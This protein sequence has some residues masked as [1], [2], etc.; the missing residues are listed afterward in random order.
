MAYTAINKSTDYFSTKLYTGTGADNNA[1]TGI[2]HQPDWV[3]IKSRSGTHSAGVHEWYDSVRGTGKMISSNQTNAEATGTNRLKSFDSDGFTLGDHNQINGG[4]TNY[5]SWSWKAGTTSGITTTG[6]DITPSYYSMSATS[7]ISIIKFTGNGVDGAKIAHGLGAVPEM[8]ISKRLENSNYW[9]VFHKLDNTDYFVLN[10][11][12]AS[13]DAPLW[14]DTN[15]TSVYYQTD[16]SNSV[17]PT[18]ETVVAYC[19]KSV[20]GFSKIGSY[21]GTNGLTFIYTGFKPKWCMFKRKDSG[22]NWKILDSDRSTFNIM[23][24]TLSADTSSAEGTESDVY[25]DFLSNGIRLDGSNGA[26][27]ASGGTYIYMAFAEAPL[28]GSNN[29]PCTAR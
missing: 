15:P 14:K 29:V 16:N 19:F 1:I 7:G 11:N 26:I 22:D 12:D 8:I 17:N 24:E 25:V 5:V 21:T 2:G 10:T 13:S 20:T 27:N 18:N 4:S 9:A 28:V 6:A 23:N 3:W